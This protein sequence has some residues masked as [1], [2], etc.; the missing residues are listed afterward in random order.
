MMKASVKGFNGSEGACHFE[1]QLCSF[2]HQFT[3]NQIVAVATGLGQLG[4]LDA[5]NGRRWY[6]SRWLMQ[7]RVGL[8]LTSTHA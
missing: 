4:S 2:S 5:G 3:V 6:A 8:G 1:I 7:G